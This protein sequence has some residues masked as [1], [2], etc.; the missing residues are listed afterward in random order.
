MDSALAKLQN[1]NLTF[2][3][4]VDKAYSVLQSY[5]NVTS[6]SMLSELHA[7]PRKFQLIKARALKGGEASNNIDFAFGHAV[8]SG[9]QAWLASGGDMDA[10]ILNGLLAWR[11]PFDMSADK[12][13]K[14]LWNA[15]IA[16]E[17]YAI[18]HREY[19]E[20]W[21][22]WTLPNGKPAIELSVSIDFENG[23]KHYIHIDVILENVLT[24]QLAVQENKTTGM[25]AV[26]E[27]I[28]ANSSQAL[29]YAVVVDMLREDTSYEVFYCV[30]SSPDREWNLL[31]FTKHTSLK[32]E[33]LNDVRL[34]HASLTTY[35][36]INFYPKRGESCYDFRRR[37]EFF[38]MCNLTG[39]ATTKDLPA[40]EEAERVDY[41]FTLS[42][43]LA[44]QHQ[45]NQKG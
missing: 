36:A 40:G 34:D 7:C 26:E 35:H 20:D 5:R 25:K 6:Y 3:D 17:K 19:L 11:L 15:C 42:Q 31:P 28:Y 16:I 33:W 37:C 24:G 32:A 27:A 13:R 38:G 4:T 14:S 1:V 39:D 45:R 29:S 2:T 10:A 21:R 23:Y 9:A 8:G 30:Y 18:F 44:R 12:V 43:I 41:S 22:V